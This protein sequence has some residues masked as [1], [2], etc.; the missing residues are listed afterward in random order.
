MEEVGV[1]PADARTGRDRM[2]L[3]L[4]VDDLVVATRLARRLKP[5][6]GVVKVGLELFISAGPVAVVAMRDEG[7]SVFLDLKLY[8]IPNTERRAARVTGALGA[9]F[10]TVPAAVGAV[11]L[12]AAVDGMTEGALEA[13]FEPPRAMAI[14]VLTSEPEAPGHLLGQR[15][16]TA[17]EAGCAGVVCA[18]AD[19]SLVKELAPS[20]FTAVPGIRP[21]GA[22]GDDHGRMS[23]PA[24]A[25]AAGADLLV[26]GRA[27]TLAADPEAAADQLA[28]TSHWSSSGV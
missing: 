9:S 3:A 6:F 18:G 13:G 10:V 21:P 11:A 15:V 16:A 26:V 23:T 5:W 8:D 14:T 2:A 4:D 22:P 19:L 7:F 20:M 17:V 27:V 24:A 25:L 12:R 1:E 28:S